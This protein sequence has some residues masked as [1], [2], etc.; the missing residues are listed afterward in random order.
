MESVC[1]DEYSEKA[2]RSTA[3]EESMET[4]DEK[5]EDNQK[6]EEMRQQAWQPSFF[7]RVDKEIHYYAGHEIS[8]W[9]SLDSYGATIWPA[10]LAL[11]QYL[12]T[13]RGTVNLLDKAVLEIGAGTGLVSI[14]ASLL[15]AWVTASDLPEV[16]GNLRS[17]LARNTRGRCRYTPQVAELTWGYGL[18]QTFPRSVYR[19]D[20]VLAADVV[21]HHDYLAE[22]LA[23]MCH[24]CQPGTTLIWSNKIRFTSDLEFF[25]KFKKAFNT[26]LLA[27]LGEV[28]I[29]SATTREAEETRNLLVKE[30]EDAKQGVDGENEE[31]EDEEDERNT[32]EFNR[33]EVCDGKAQD[34]NPAETK[35]KSSVC[36]EECNEEANEDSYEEQELDMDASAEENLMTGKNK[37]DPGQMIQSNSETQRTGGTDKNCQVE[38]KESEDEE[39][40]LQSEM[41]EK[42][43]DAE[44]DGQ[45]AYRKAWEPSLYFMPGKEIHYFLGHKI[46]IEE[47]I[48]SYGAVIWPA[49]V[50]LCKFL[51]TPEGQQQIN[52]LDKSVLEI[53]A[54]TGLLS[55]AATL[56]GAKLT[57]TD[58]PEILSN[59]RFNLNRNTRQHRRHEPRVMELS[60][61]H[62]LEETF[63]H[64][65]YHYDYVL[66]ADVVYHHGFLAEL[67]DTMHHFC[68]PGT[69][70]IWANKIRYSSDLVFVENFEKTFHVTL[71]AELGEVKIYKATHK[72]AE[73]SNVLK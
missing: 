62:K 64:S 7:I 48:D 28:K 65:I 33:R 73:D 38:S 49:A 36:L 22:L 66:A 61:G 9:Q 16:L 70:L 25:E 8:I 53:G 40:S 59:L 10:A 23:T 46:S 5:E 42:S 57:A 14:V 13:N 52:L 4:E 35:S 24:F 41:E 72:S 55:I 34:Q 26:T 68:Q 43:A 50:A 27:D 44:K 15:G 1:E 30:V 20:Y 2:E 69:T 63:P 51:D 12:D 60:W 39:S 6:H 31:E 56:L 17:N 21:Y 19:Y 45:L 37:N 32:K 47:S 71:I 67:L 54:G 3:K 29:Y 18:T 11:C 58:L